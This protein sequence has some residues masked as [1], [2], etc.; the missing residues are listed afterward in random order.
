M[1]DPGR[2][3]HRRCSSDRAYLS[4]E[5][6]TWGEPAETNPGVAGVATRTAQMPG[7]VARHVSEAAPSD[8]SF[9]AP[10]R[11]HVV[12]RGARTQK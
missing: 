4:T 3:A 6:L 12:E 5:T 1:A 8:D 7:P 11:T 10:A 9:A 2:V